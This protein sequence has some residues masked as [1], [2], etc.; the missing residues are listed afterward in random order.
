MADPYPLRPV[1]P[2]EFD[3]YHAVDEHAFH[4]RPLSPQRREEHLRQFEADRSLA[5][6]DRDRPVGVAGVYTLQMSVPG[7]ILP[8][9]G[10]TWVAVLP[11]HGRHVLGSLSLVPH[12]L[13]T[14]S[15]SF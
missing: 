12:H 9:A 3:A 4:N 5:A 13:L 7:A 1:G 10:V 2:E 8:A 14:A 6:F 15:D 11:S